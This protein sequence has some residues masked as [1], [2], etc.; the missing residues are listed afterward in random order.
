MAFQYESAEKQQFDIEA[1]IQIEEEEEMADVTKQQEIPPP[2]QSPEI[3]IVEDDEEIEEEQPEI[4]NEINNGIEGYQFPLNDEE[5]E[6]EGIFIAVDEDPSFPG[7]Q[8]ALHQ[9]LHNTIEYP[10][11]ALRAGIEGK[12]EVSFVVKAD[13]S[14]TDV[15]IA[16]NGGVSRELNKE[17]LRVVKN[18]PNWEPGKQREHPVDVRVELPIHF[19][20]AR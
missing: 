14:I 12:V 20:L 2:P 17:A 8:G 10:E 18:M 13:G 5:V 9:Y 7:G 15:G 11:K 16:E 4:D 6:D 1:E 19:R 3:D